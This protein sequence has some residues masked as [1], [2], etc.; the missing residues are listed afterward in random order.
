MRLLH[1]IANCF[2]VVLY[3]LND[4]CNIPKNI[5]AYLL[6]I[7]SKDAGPA[8]L[9]RWR[10]VSSIWSLP[11]R[12]RL[13]RLPTLQF[14]L[15]DLAPFLH[16]NSTKQIPHLFGLTPASTGHARP[17]QWRLNPPTSKIRP[18][19]TTLHDQSGETLLFNLISP[20]CLRVLFRLQNA[21]N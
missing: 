4:A 10:G 14:V 13:F 2:L 6:Q 8:V 11:W 21:L 9:L 20:Y 5:W 18:P 15:F 7:F 19:P 16:Y 12:R 17:P 3:V 1:L